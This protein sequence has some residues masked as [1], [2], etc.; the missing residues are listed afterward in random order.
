MKCNFTKTKVVVFNASF[1]STTDR[2]HLFKICG[3]VVKREKEYK[4]LG[5]MMVQGKTVHGML[6]HATR[7][8]QRAIAVLHKTFHRLHVA[9]NINLKLKLFSSLVMPN[10]TFACE[11][12]GPWILHA[13]LAGKAFENTV[14]QTRLSFAR[15]LLGLK[16]SVPSWNVYRELGWYPLMVY[17]ARQVVRYMNK[18][19]D[20]QSGTWAK[21]AMLDAWMMYKQ[22]GCMNW[23]AQFDNF[24]TALGMQPTELYEGLMPIY[25]DVAVQKA[26]QVKCHQVYL[27]PTCSSKLA[28]YN[29]QF[30]W[31]LRRE[32]GE[33]V[34]RWLTAPYLLLPVPSKKLVLLA[35]FRLSCHYL[36]IETGRWSRTLVD[37]RKCT[38]CGDGSVQDEHHHIFACQH[39]AEDRAQFPRIFGNGQFSTIQSLFILDKSC[40]AEWHLV[41]R[42]LCRFLHSTG[43]IYKTIHRVDGT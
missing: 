20:M 32:D 36:A 35:R 24:M 22:H 13:D 43:G 18:L 21:M 4:Y 10:L 27:T 12:W 6:R 26:L 23:C 7:R 38:L 2:N 3:E 28:L 19:V 9:S 5:T 29:A 17:V 42:D 34:D 16:T 25:D 31:P 40:T 8:G 33:V 30:G 41:V 1:V 39:L 11:V 37:H 15:V 14:E